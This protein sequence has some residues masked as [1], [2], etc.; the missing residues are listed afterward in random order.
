MMSD[1]EN[2]ST[3]TL[4]TSTRRSPHPPVNPPITFVDGF[5]PLPKKR[6]IARTFTGDEITNMQVQRAQKD[7]AELET[8]EGESQR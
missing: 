7:A 2:T 3:Q 1:D 4:T 5:T 6:R 8:K